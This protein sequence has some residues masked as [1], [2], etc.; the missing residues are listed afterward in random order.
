MRPNCLH[1][2]LATTTAVALTCA[3]V[4]AQADD[5]RREVRTSMGNLTVLR[6][7]PEAGT[8]T[9]TLW[10]C[11]PHGRGRYQDH[12]QY[13]ADLALRWRNKGVAVGVM[14]PAKDAKA[15]AAAEPGTL[16][17]AIDEGA[18]ERAA[19][20]AD[21][22]AG[23]VRDDGTAETHWWNF[24]GAVD[25][26]ENRLAGKEDQA[27]EVI[28]QQ[29]ASLIA[30]V[31]DGGEFGEQ[32]KSC[33]NAWPRSGRARAAAVLYYW[34]C[35]G[36]LDKANAAID[37][38]IN[39][40]ANDAPAMTEFADLV[41]RGDHNNRSNARKLAMAMAPVA[42]GAAEGAYTQLVYLRALLHA[43]QDRVAGRVAAKL[44]K[45]VKGDAWQ[46]LVFA[47]TLMDADTPAVFRD[48][49]VRAIDASKASGALLR[50]TFAAR[51]KV[52]SRCGE[53]KAAAELMTQYRAK[54]IGNGS[55]N[56]D[57]WYLIV[58]PQTM[59]RFDSLA[60]AQ[61]EEMLRVEGAGI[62]F[63]SK[64]TVALAYFVNGRIDE[65]VE[66]QSEATQ[67]SG[68]QA[69]YLGR[70]TRFEAIKQLRDANPA[71]DKK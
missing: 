9:W 68:N 1:A 54:N 21:S 20:V 47:E 37:D 6:E 59:G 70:L 12:R 71:P 40:L 62:D 63:G 22:L 57:A 42:A 53:S 49:A 32:V 55:L 69:T 17:A 66:L 27:P 67:A 39:A 64:D 34:W 3:S 50:W 31:C 58:Q 14:M 26:V 60:L 51:H 65:A 15:V 24:D 52:L 30:N 28:E 5:A 36:D 29:L 56:N 44:Q 33:L 13:L 18:N 25:I 11:Y 35:K 16:V 7:L 61:A 19:A 41:L 38:G 45:K 8:T 10:V 2:V 48:L 4:R 43:G 46:Q 23:L